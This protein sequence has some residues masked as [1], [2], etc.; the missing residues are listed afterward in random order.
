[1]SGLRQFLVSIMVF[2]MA[3]AAGPVVASKL[4]DQTGVDAPI[5]TRSIMSPIKIDAR[6]Q[7]A[8]KV[9]LEGEDCGIMVEV[10][11]AFATSDVKTPEEMY[12]ACSAC[13]AA[14]VAGAPKL[15]DKGAWRPRIAKGKDSLYKNAINGINMMPPKGTCATC[16]DD[17][18]KAIVDYMVEQSQ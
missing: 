3:A 12:S 17:D 1:M 6:T 11:G 10:A 4:S 5:G 7:P 13:H 18:I 9:C 15:G 8:A 16:S 14:G 2:V